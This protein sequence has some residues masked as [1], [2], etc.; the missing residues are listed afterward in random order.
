LFSEQLA[1]SLPAR[2]LSSR[3]LR[4]HEEYPHG[5]FPIYKYSPNL[6]PSINHGENVG[7]QIRK[8]PFLLLESKPNIISM[9]YIING[10]QMSS[11]LANF[12]FTFQNQIFSVCL[13]SR[14]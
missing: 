5:S 11:Y 12:L 10:K 14:R 4:H 7:G 13:Q 6:T 8:K 3:L 9:K 1:S 2:H